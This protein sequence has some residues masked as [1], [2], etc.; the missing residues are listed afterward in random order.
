L[1]RA[2]LLTYGTMKS[3]VSGD[4]RKRI[5][6]KV[7]LPV[8]LLLVAAIIAFVFARSRPKAADKH[9]IEPANSAVGSNISSTPAP[10]PNIF[11]S[12]HS[13][14]SARASEFESEPETARLRS[15]MLDDSLPLR[16]RREAA[17]GL[18]KI[19]T[20]EAMAALKSALTN[21]TAPFVKAA[22]AEGLGQSPNAE[23]PELLHQLVTGKDQTV[24]RGAARGF[25]ARGDTDA[26]NTLGK[27]LFSDQTP[28]SV[29]TESALALG[30]V[31][32][33]SAQDLLTKAISQIQDDD[34]QE[35]VIDGLARRPFSDTEEFFRN[36]L[37]SP[38]VPSASKVLAIESIRDADGDVEAFLSNYLNDANPEVRAAAKKAL[39]FLDPD[40]PPAAAPSL[41]AQ[42]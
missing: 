34:V 23:A 18:A 1:S 12:L 7:L 13:A 8:W 38:D 24:A 39:D 5:R 33:P 35:S 14:E 16:Q 6:T 3:N 31:S 10:T 9:S 2:N 20:D 21:N 4:S 42:Q 22:I 37:N 28:L 27:L 15:I 11:P 32:S 19:G 36:Y 40:T 30:D 17:R 25:A 26:V 29:R 41:S